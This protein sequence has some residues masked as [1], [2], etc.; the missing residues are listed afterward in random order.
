MYIHVYVCIFWT[1]RSRRRTSESEKGSRRDWQCTSL[2]A[3]HAVTLSRVPWSRLSVAICHASSTTPLPPLPMTFWARYLLRRF[4]GR[5]PLSARVPSSAPTSRRLVVWERLYKRDETYAATTTA[6][7]RHPATIHG[8]GSNG[9]SFSSMVGI[10]VSSPLGRPWRMS[11]RLIELTSS[12][13]AVCLALSSSF[14]A[15]CHHHI[16]AQCD[17]VAHAVQVRAAHESEV[18]GVKPATGHRWRPQE[19]RALRLPPLRASRWR[20]ARSSRS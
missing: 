11:S 1:S 5:S 10:D 6:P 16:L 7:A 13:P 3:H 15:I 20:F 17:S 4:G 18:G 14:D 12:S 8:V 19:A 2:I 9:F